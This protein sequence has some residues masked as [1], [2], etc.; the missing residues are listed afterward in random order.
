VSI[1]TSQGIVYNVS[2]S[3]PTFATKGS[4]IT[5]SASS[6]TTSSFLQISVDGSTKKTCY[7]TSFC[8]TTYTT[9]TSIKKHTISAS[10]ESTSFAFDFANTYTRLHFGKS[11]TSD[12]PRSTN[13]AVVWD[14]AYKALQYGKNVQ[15][16]LNPYNSIYDAIKSIHYFARDIIQPNYASDSDSLTAR[17]VANYFTSYSPSSSSYTTSR[18]FDCSDMAAFIAGMANNLRITNRLIT[19]SNLAAGSMTVDYQHFVVELYGLTVNGNGGYFL[20]DPGHPSSYYSSYDSAATIREYAFSMI[21]G[22]TKLDRLHI[23]S[24]WTSNWGSSVADSSRET[25]WKSNYSPYTW[26][27]PPSYTKYTSNPWGITV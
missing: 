27:W 9:S 25:G 16:S 8:S 2:V 1:P 4:T 22:D 10:G 3:A 5:I 11:I 18:D 12:T 26:P 21:N 20:V 7:S 13:D 19:L 17:E 15:T 23:V 6:S 24:G 14:I